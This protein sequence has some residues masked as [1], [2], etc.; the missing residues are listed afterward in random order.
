MKP[1]GLVA[2]IALL[3]AGG[4][5]T[6]KF[7]VP[8]NLARRPPQIDALR[9][10]ILKDTHLEPDIQV[11]QFNDEV[12]LSARMNIVFPHVPA[13]ANKEEI[14]R[15]VRLLVK[16]HLP[17]ARE[18]DVQFGDNLGKAKALKGDRGLTR[19]QRAVEKLIGVEPQ[20][21]R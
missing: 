19:S 12:D 15:S 21:P 6:Y 10:A 7:L 20:S 9:A 11:K 8:E 17:A 13:A 4:W 14:E 1:L 5:Y 16:E 2:L 3:A 18:V